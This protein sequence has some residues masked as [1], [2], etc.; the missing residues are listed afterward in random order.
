M[1]VALNASLHDEGGVRGM[2]RK[3]F[4]QGGTDAV[5]DDDLEYRGIEGAVLD[6]T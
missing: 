6:M 1:F 4:G 5:Q 2:A 3:R